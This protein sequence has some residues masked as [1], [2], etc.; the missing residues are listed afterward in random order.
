MS[1]VH[2]EDYFGLIE[3]VGSKGRYQRNLILLFYAIWFVTA[4]V[5]LGVSFL[6]MSNDF[7]CPHTKDAL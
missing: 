5:I 4:F 7:V 3:R 6:L 2:D 1:H